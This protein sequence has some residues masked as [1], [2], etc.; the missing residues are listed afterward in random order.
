MRPLNQGWRETY[1]RDDQNRKVNG[2]IELDGSD[3][4]EPAEA[5]KRE[6]IKRL[7]CSYLVSQNYSRI[8]Q[9]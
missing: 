3:V 7:L 4:C 5:Y 8:T 1:R 2:R 9:N 6:D